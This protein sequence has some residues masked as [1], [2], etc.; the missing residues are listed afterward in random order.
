MKYKLGHGDRTPGWVSGQ[1]FFTP[2]VLVGPTS[3]QSLLAGQDEGLDPGP[4]LFCWP[5]VLSFH[6]CSLG[7]TS[8]T[9]SRTAR[10]SEPTWRRASPAKGKCQLC[11][12]SQA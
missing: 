3:H 9:S 6:A 4:I 5:S 12:S 1:A 11:P 2:H 8:L 7:G 10:T